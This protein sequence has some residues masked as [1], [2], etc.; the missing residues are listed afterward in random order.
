MVALCSTSTSTPPIA[1]ALRLEILVVKHEILCA[2]T[3]HLTRQSRGTVQKRAA[4]HLYVR[5]HHA[6]RIHIIR[7]VGFR[8]YQCRR[9]VCGARSYREG[10]RIPKG[11]I[12]VFLWRVLS[13]SR[14]LHG[15]NHEDVLGSRWC[16]PGEVY[17]R[18]KCYHERRAHRRRFRTKV[19]QH[20]CLLCEGVF[21]SQGAASAVVR[22]R[23]SSGDY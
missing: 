11:C 17:A 6:P 5:D 9:N 20:Q 2:K 22:L 12:R 4:P 18:G 8:E 1:F 7:T 15:W 14:P 19:K 23:R 3:Q 16:K 10:N 13:N 21:Y